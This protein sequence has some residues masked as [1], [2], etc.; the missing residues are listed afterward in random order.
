[1]VRRHCGRRIGVGRIKGVC[2]D[3]YRCLLRRG[4]NAPRRC[5]PHAAATAA[6]CLP[7][8]AAACRRLRAAPHPRRRLHQ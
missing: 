2:R 7:S 3:A 5:L 8:D 6:A 4:V 1:M